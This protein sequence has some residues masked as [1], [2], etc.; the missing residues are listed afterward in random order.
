MVELAAVSEV[1]T[2]CAKSNIS[3]T[4]KNPEALEHWK[5]RGGWDG[6][7]SSS[8]LPIAYSVFPPRESQNS[9][10]SPPSVIFT[11]SRPGE[12]AAEILSAS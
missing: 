4:L 3:S 8:H 5:R 12:T 9:G 1:V 2:C 11:G 10:G 7:T 6:V